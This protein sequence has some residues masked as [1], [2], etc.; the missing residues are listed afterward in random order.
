MPEGHAK[1]REA[2]S[3]KKCISVSENLIKCHILHHNYDF[4]K[5]QFEYTLCSLI[6]KRVEVSM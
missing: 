4:L 2:S 5:F 3:F 6:L 1:L